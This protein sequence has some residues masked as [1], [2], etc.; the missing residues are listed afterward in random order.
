LTIFKK[1]LFFDRAGEEM[2]TDLSL[3]MLYSISPLPHIYLSVSPGHF[4]NSIT[5]ILFEL[6]FVNIAVGPVIDTI[7]VALILVILA[8]EKFAIFAFPLPASFSLTIHKLPVIFIFIAPDIMTISVRLIIYVLSLVNISIA[9]ILESPSFFLK[10][11][12]RIINVI[13]LTFLQFYISNIDCGGFH[14]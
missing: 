6:S 7:A 10:Q 12:L 4:A 11:F 3:T 5:I 2:G 9:E 8:L 14:Y 13:L 1:K